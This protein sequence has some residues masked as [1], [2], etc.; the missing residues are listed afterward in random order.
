MSEPDYLFVYGSLMQDGH[1]TIHPLLKP[2]AVCMGKATLPGLLYEILGYP[3]AISCAAARQPVIH[4]EVYRLLDAQALFYHLDE[5]EECSASFPSPHEYQRC[6]MPVNLYGYGVIPAWVYLY[7][8]PVAGL[9]LIASG[10]YRLYC[11]SRLV[12]T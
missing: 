2:H 4:G 6:K 7:K 8:R 10:D 9:K 12:Q 1:G 5:Y 3:G 11:Q